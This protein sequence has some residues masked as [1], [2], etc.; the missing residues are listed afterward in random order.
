M[1]GVWLKNLEVALSQARYA[2]GLK[3]ELD[4]REV[5]LEICSLGTVLSR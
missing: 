3:R 1:V 2:V 5:I 4:P